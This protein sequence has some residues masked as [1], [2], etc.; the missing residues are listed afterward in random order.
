MCPIVN[1]SPVLPPYLQPGLRHGKQKIRQKSTDP[2]TAENQVWHYI[3]W[4]L[5]WP[6]DPKLS[7]FFSRVRV[8]QKVSIK[9]EIQILLV[10]KSEPRLHSLYKW[11]QAAP[12]IICSPSWSHTVPQGPW[13]P[14][15]LLLRQTNGTGAMR[16][17]CWQCQGR[18]K[19]TVYVEEYG[20]TQ[21]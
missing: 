13:R 11:T 9:S 3:L 16:K 19:G 2:T 8:W 18:K 17:F 21:A 20:Q 12:T 4:T 1:N 5:I 10:R 15:G 7:A 14:T 6:Q